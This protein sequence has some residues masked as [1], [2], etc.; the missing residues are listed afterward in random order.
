MADGEV[1]I[2]TKIDE[3]GVDKGLSSIKNKLNKSSKDIG[4]NSK[5]LNGLKSAFN[6][7]GSSASGFA[8]KMQGI[9]T[10]GGAV[11]V[12]L[13]SAVVAAKKIIQTLKE[14]NEAYKV[15]EKAE[16]ALAKAAENNP[17]LNRESVQKLK[18]YA[19]ELQ[20]ISNYGDEGTIDIMAQLASTGRSESEIMKIMGAAAD[21]AAAKHIDLKTAAETLNSTYSGMAG[22]MGRQISEIKDLTD[23]QLK[24][25]D[26]IDLISQKYKGFAKESIDSGTQA[27]NAFGDFM[28]SLGKIANPTFEALGRR[29]KA[30]WENMT[31]L[32]TDFNKALENASRKWSIGGIK[33]GV[34]EGVKVINTEY[35]DSKTGK[36][37][38]AVE[39][40]PK[41]YLEWLKKELEI[42]KKI[43]GELASEEMQALLSINEEIRKRNEIEKTEKLKL[44]KDKNEGDE[45]IKNS[46]KKLQESLKALEVE[47]KAKGE[48][49]AAQDKYNLYLQSYID[50]LT[51]TEG[52]IK[53]G[54]PVEQKRLEQLKEAKKAL[55]KAADSEKKLSAAIQYTKTVTE[56][57]NSANHN[58]TPTAELEAEIKKLDEIK[59]KI[60]EMS[61][62]EVKTAQKGEKTQFSKSQLLAGL[63]EAE[64]Q[65]TL[66]KVKTMTSSEKNWWD[67]YKSE[68]EQIL[69]MKK[70]IDESEVLSEEEKIKALKALDE[71]YSKSRKEQFAELA[72]QIKGYTDQAVDVMN[73][74]SALMLNTLKNQTDA[75]LATLETKYRKGEISEEEFEEKKSQI[76]KD[77][78]KKQYKIDMA[79]WAANLLQ[80]TANIALGVTKAIAMGGPAGII[81]GALVGAAGAVQIASLIA[82]KPTPPSFATGG[83]V[84]GMN[85]ATMGSDNTYAHVRNGEWIVN[86]AQQRRLWELSNGIGQGFNGGSANI[87]INNN[88]SN[89]VSAKPQISKDKIELMIDA[90]VNESLKSG[91][92]S[93]SLAYAESESGGSFYGI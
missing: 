88:A 29:A 6:E 7:A 78:A 33:K 41:E 51:K 32:M 53:E 20:N 76:K 25:G 54:Y 8:S 83:F 74:A 57:L 63:D 89:M 45:Y 16:K 22:T 66:A 15:Q 52:K 24:N 81:T 49:V 91:R 36:T 1:K 79:T 71:S 47:A 62:A 69:E 9:A 55:D 18:D 93:K 77:A 61:E 43:N 86:A 2:D 85:G 44:E 92:Y 87:V 28:E 75:E 17:Y 37:R 50:L 10:S 70:A 82:S 72:T 23:E 26:A 68:Q 19:S 14:A 73:Q 42:R 64:K 46:N 59:A 35:T 30:F 90:R 3:S 11:G 13:T 39:I 65:A 21:Y 38:D 56:T 84:G 60:K 48:V 40:Q 27:K 80:A 34:D 67:K 12:A 31:S 5:S 4:K 58:L